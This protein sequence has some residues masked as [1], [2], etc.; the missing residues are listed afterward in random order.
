MS[1]ASSCELL[2]LH[3]VR[4]L[5]WASEA[6]VAGRWRLDP[7]EVREHL[8]DAEA[9]G[10]VRHTAFAGRS[11][12]SM[13]DAGR[14]GNERQLAEELDA[15][16]ARRT[17]LAA[18]AAFLPLNR[19]FGT[20]CTRWQVRPQPWDPMAANDHGDWPWDEAV[21]RTLTALGTALEHNT[22]APL[23]AVLSRFD[24]HVARY[25]AA[26]SRVDR[27]ERAWVDAPDRASCHLVW[28]QLHEDLLA[29]L[30][31]ERGSDG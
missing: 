23:V 29:T 6:Q 3:G 22:C 30:G 1:H 24:G 12:W 9:R 19:R 8:L 28:I 10:W 18:H 27:G 11:G 5:G 4:I 16:G 26:L 13:T 14:Q 20:A 17:A 31:I 2:A 21:L 25:R 7:V 15:V